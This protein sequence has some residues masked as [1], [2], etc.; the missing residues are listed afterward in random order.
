MRVKRGEKSRGVETYESNIDT[1]DT[2]S[3]IVL[4]RGDHL[5]D[6]FTGIC[7]R[8]DQHFE[9]VCPPL[10]ILS[11]DTLQCHIR[12]AMLHLLQHAGN[13]LALWQFAVVKGLHFGKFLLEVIQSPCP[14]AAVYDD[15]SLGA[16]DEGHLGGHLADGAG[17]PDSNN[18]AFSDAGVNDAVPGCGEDIGEVETFLIGDR[19]GEGKEVDVAEGD[20]DV[21]G[22]TTSETTCKVGVSE[23]TWK[24][25]SALY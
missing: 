11:S 10:R 13:A 23:H 18:V 5:I 19:V 14:V 24:G 17:T 6:N 8:P 7:L 4:Y 21:F 2:A 25:L 16:V 9:V 22:L 12:T 15:D 1:S 3:T 20:A